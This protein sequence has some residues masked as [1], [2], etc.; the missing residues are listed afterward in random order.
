MGFFHLRRAV[1]AGSARGPVAVSGLAL[2]AVGEFG[3]RRGHLVF[4]LF[5]SVRVVLPQGLGVPG[6]PTSEENIVYSLEGYLV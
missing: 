2:L 3:V 5:F 1:F 4:H 6:G